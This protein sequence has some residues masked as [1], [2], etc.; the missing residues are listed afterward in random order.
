[1]GQYYLG[2][3]DVCPDNKIID[4]LIINDQ[5]R[6]T[7]QIILDDNKLENILQGKHTLRAEYNTRQSI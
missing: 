4:T 1:M 6:N 3:I 5:T 2:S 7:N